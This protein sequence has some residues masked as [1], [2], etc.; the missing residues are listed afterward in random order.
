VR[1]PSGYHNVKI[2][3]VETQINE[4]LG[5]FSLG[6]SKRSCQLP[7][8]IS[9][10]FTS[11]AS[12]FH[13]N[14]VPFQRL[15]LEKFGDIRGEGRIIRGGRRSGKWIRTIVISSDLLLPT[16][17]AEDCSTLWTWRRLTFSW[18]IW[19]DITTK[20]LRYLVY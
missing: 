12:G 1:R 2:N 3:R 5:T 19:I 4:R 16:T 18:G 15:L 13:S 20:L 11:T 17:E 9:M 14:A 7:I 10:Q 8:N 6:E